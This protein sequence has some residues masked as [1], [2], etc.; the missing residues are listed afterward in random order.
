MHRG[1]YIQKKI[2]ESG[3]SLTVLSEKMDIARTTLYS[4]MSKSDMPYNKMMQ[5]ADIIKIDITQDFPEIINDSVSHL[6]SGSDKVDFNTYFNLKEKYTLLLEKYS[7]IQEELKTLKE[8]G[9]N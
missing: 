8:K 4:W 1:N 7:M 3:I 2:K 5:I 6:R 9:N